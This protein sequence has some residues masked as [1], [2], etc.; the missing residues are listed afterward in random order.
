MKLVHD[1]HV[2]FGLDNETG[3]VLLSD[4]EK[5]F[6]MA[7]MLEE[8]YEYRDAQ[9]LVGQYDALL[10]LIVFAVGTLERHGFP[11]LEGFEAVMRANMTK[12]VGQNGA[13]RGGFKRDLVKPA[14]FVGPEST[15]DEILSR[16]KIAQ[17]TAPGADGKIVPGFAPKFDAD[18]VRLDLLP[19]GPMTEIAE[20]FTFG[21]KKYFA[22]SYRQGETVAFSRTYGSILRHLFAYWNGEDLDPESGKSH[23]AHAGTQLCILMEHNKHNRN[24]DDRFARGEK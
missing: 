24:K 14:D 4:E 18:K 9:T 1:M 22:D 11:L 23:L 7:A 8:L 20:V 19:I 2:K 21:A 5:D 10:D 3:P 17:T 13:K 16:P 12:S 15:L 6:R